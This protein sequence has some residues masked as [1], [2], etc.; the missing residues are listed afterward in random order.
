HRPQSRAM[1]RSAQGG[2]Q[3]GTVQVVW[4]GVHARAPGGCT[5]GFFGGVLRSVLQ[6]RTPQGGGKPELAGVSAEARPPP[7][8]VWFGDPQTEMAQGA[9][10]KA[11]RRLVEG[12]CAPLLFG[13]NREPL[14]DAARLPVT[15]GQIAITTDSFVV[16]PITFP[17]GSIGEL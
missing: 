13:S 1:R 5:D 4:K 2:T 3:A 10:G 7:A 9:G 12:L 11:S 8:R 6:L 17:G 15:G 16:S 14:A